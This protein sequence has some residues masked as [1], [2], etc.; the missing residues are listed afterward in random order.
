MNIQKINK[1]NYSLLA[2]N[3]EHDDDHV[4]VVTDIRGQVCTMTKLEAVIL[5]RYKGSDKVDEI[6]IQMPDSVASNGTC[7]QQVDDETQQNLIWGN[8]SLCLIYARV[9]FCYFE[10]EVNL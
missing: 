9:S 5:L 3:E 10:S 6:E 8:F 1:Y 7:S 4:H 2:D